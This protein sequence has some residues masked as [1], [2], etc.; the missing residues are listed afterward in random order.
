M[1]NFAS[2]SGIPGLTGVNMFA[3]LWQ[4]VVVL[5]IIAVFFGFDFSGRVLVDCVLP[6]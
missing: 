5:I 6:A 2:G 1:E 4:A 3:V